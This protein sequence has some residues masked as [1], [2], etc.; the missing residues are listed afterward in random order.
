MGPHSEG[1][2][3]LDH[4]HGALDDPR[5]LACLGAWLAVISIGMAAL[6]FTG[7]SVGP[8]ADP[9]AQIGSTGAP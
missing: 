1:T 2:E 8:A 7:E 3:S 6:W 4:A 5:M 9:V